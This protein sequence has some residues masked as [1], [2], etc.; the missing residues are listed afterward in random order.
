M[1]ADALYQLRIV[2]LLQSRGIFTASPVA[3]YVVLAND[4][5]MSL[6]SWDV[7]KL[8]P[9][10]TDAQIAAVSN[11][12]A[13]AASGVQAQRAAQAY[14]DAMPIFEKALL[15]TLLDQINLLRSKFTPILIPITMSQV[16]QAVRD[17]AG[18]L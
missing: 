16:I 11:A 6:A 10:P 13:N 5:E 17:K 2:A 18:T 14:I 9:K 1:P 15:F 3:D 8:G 4:G 7:G 12:Q